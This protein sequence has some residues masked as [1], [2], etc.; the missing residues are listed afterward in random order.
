MCAQCLAN[1]EAYQNALGIRC[2]GLCKPLPPLTHSVPPSPASGAAVSDNSKF[3]ALGAFDGKVRLISAYSWQVAFVLPLT[4]P[5]EMEAGFN[6]QDLQLTVEISAVHSAT[7]LSRL[8]AADEAE[9]TAEDASAASGIC[10]I[11]AVITA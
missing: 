6:S 5:R 11:R 10:A 8:A 1:F 4:H 2:L 7:I 9:E 3:L